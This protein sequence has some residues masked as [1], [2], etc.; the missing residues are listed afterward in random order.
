MSVKPNIIRCRQ[1]WLQEK[2]AWRAIFRALF[3]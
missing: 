1:Q 3:A 2:Q